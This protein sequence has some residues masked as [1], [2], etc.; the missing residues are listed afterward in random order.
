MV[1]ALF[2]ATAL[3]ADAVPEENRLGY[4]VSVDV[5]RQMV[6]GA[7]RAMRTRIPGLLCCVLARAPDGEAADAAARMGARVVEV[8]GPAPPAGEGRW[9]AR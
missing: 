8:G 4:A 6:D 9:S 7:G 5:V 3:A 1:L 2:A